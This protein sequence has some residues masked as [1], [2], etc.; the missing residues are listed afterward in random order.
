MASKVQRVFALFEGGDVLRPWC[1]GVVSYL[2]L[3]GAA[4]ALPHPPYRGFSLIR[5]WAQEKVRCERGRRNTAVLVNSGFV[6]EF[7]GFRFRVAGFGFG[8]RRNAPRLADAAAPA[9]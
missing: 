9:R 2:T 4:S 8:P 3:L 5:K 6:G 7:G 1:R